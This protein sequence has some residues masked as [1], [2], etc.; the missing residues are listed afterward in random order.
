MNI[1]SEGS[2]LPTALHR[3]LRVLATVFMLGAAC[4][5]CGPDARAAEAST[6]EDR[7]R[8]IVREVIREN[9]E[10]IYDTLNQ[11]AAERKQKQQEQQLEAS[12]QNR[13][14]DTVADH[15]PRKG[16]ADAP[17]TIIEYTDFQCPYCARGA[18]TLDQV[19]KRY[20]D[21]VRVI[22][23]N[24]PLKMH[25]QAEAAA[26]AALAARRQGKFW[27]YHDLLFQKAS[28]LKDDIYADLAGSL[29]L[30]VEQFKADMTSAEVAAELRADL[31]RAKALGL[32]GT[33]R[34]LV[35]GVQIRG[36]YPPEYFAMVIDRLLAETN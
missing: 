17:V 6:D 13:I 27:E 20:P 12:F 34:F 35:N 14:E 7:I 22:F 8:T 33:P 5:A 29:G 2:L 28:V 24:L 18:R 10:L 15:N 32:R 21:Q 36:A 23:K 3:G 30:N 11:Y 16:P 1:V 25:D 26:R 4:A 19:L 31:D 9:P